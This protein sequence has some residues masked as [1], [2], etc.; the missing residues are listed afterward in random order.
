[1]N[2]SGRVRPG[3]P[4]RGHFKYRAVMEQKRSPGPE[5]LVIAGC[6]GSAWGAALLADDVIGRFPE[7][8]RI[9]CFIDSARGFK[10][11]WPRIATEVWGA[12]DEIVARLH[13]TDIVRDSLAALYRS[14]GDRVHFL[15][16]SSIRDSAL[17]RMQNHFDRKGLV[18]TRGAGEEFQR[19]RDESRTDARSPRHRTRLRRHPRFGHEGNGVDD[20]LSHPRQ[21]VP[22]QNFGREGPRDWTWDAVN[23]NLHSYWLSLLT[24]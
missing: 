8:R 10:D 7:R 23:G 9:T 1:M 24:D 18:F 14:L 11:D 2:R 3:G 21:I 15:Y 5:D 19:G 13:P 16:S 20:A 4:P 17:V 12:P 6:S 22:P